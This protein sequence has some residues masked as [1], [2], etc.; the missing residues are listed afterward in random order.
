M[1]IKPPPPSCSQREVICNSNPTSSK[2]LPFTCSEVIDLGTSSFCAAGG[3]EGGWAW[4]SGETGFLWRPEGSRVSPAS[5]MASLS[6]SQGGNL[7]PEET[8][9]RVQAPP[10]HHRRF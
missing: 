10:P 2:H 3:G 5:F 9:V 1:L 4:W 6:Y 8:L 7:G